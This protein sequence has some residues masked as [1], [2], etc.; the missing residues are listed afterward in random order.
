MCSL[1]TGDSQSEENLK[2]IV[3]DERM[4]AYL[5]FSLVSFRAESKG[6]PG[7][8]EPGEFQPKRRTRSG[9]AFGGADIVD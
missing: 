8:V 1:V 7:G 2:E 3:L 4:K 9:F 5:R 6:E